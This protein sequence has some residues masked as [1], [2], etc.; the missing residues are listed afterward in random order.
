MGCGGCLTTAVIGQILFL[1]T[2][3]KRCENCFKLQNSGGRDPAWLHIH[4]NRTEQS[5]YW[6]PL[7]RQK[8]GFGVPWCFKGSLLPVLLLEE[9][10]ILKAKGKCIRNTIYHNTYFFWAESSVFAHFFKKNHSVM[11]YY[12]SSSG[13]QKFPS[14]LW[15]YVQSSGTRLLRI[16][17]L[18][19]LG[20]TASLLCWSGFW[21]YLAKSVFCNCS[22][23]VFRWRKKYSSRIPSV[24]FLRVAVT[25]L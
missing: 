20:V 12:M 18:R 13:S 22:S 25:E 4:L 2:T 11:W 17:L 1:V 9:L 23:L 10:V 19:N 7:S 3:E 6:F 24:T 8:G 14:Q 5:M 16:S 21:F 15:S